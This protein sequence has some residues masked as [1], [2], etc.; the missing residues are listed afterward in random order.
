MEQVTLSHAMR[1]LEINNHRLDQLLE[2]TGIVPQIASNDR[3][4]KLITMSQLEQLR[5]A[6]IA[7][8]RPSLSRADLSNME[9][10]SVIA[11]ILLRLETLERQ[12]ATYM[13]QPARPERRPASTGE[14]ALTRPAPHHVPA[15][16][17]GIGKGNAAR[18]ALRHGANS[19]KSVM[20]WYWQESDLVDE[21]T[22]LRFI[23]TYLAGHRAGVWHIC[24]MS[25]CL[26]HQ[27]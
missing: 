21:V 6:H 5:L 26:C 23:K 12:I 7:K 9:G 4:R 20:D 10:N 8:L 19:Y 25:D 27:I 22:A 1:L 13:M 2:S 24:T 18:M 17:I 11:T 3:R 15:G 16:Q 14:R